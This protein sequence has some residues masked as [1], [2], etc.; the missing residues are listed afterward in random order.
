MKKQ[1]PQLTE[2]QKHR[3]KRQKQSHKALK[4][5]MLRGNGLK[6]LFLT[7][8]LTVGIAIIVYTEAQLVDGFDSDEV[9]KLNDIGM[10]I[11]AD[12]GFEGRVLTVAPSLTVYGDDRRVK[13]MKNAEIIPDVQIN[14]KRKSEGVYELTPVV[15]DDKF[16]LNYHFS[17]STVEVQ[18]LKAEKEQYDVLERHYAIADEG[19]YIERM[20]AQ[21]MAEVLVTSEQAMEIG[22]VVADIDAEVIKKSGIYDADLVILDKR[23]QIL[24]LPLVKPTIKIE[25]TYSE[26]PWYQRQKDILALK[27]E[28]A[29]LET[30][31]A[32]RR[33]RLPKVSDLLQRSDLV[34]EISFR[35][36]RLPIKQK[37]LIE[38]ET[39][40]SEA[41]ANEEN[42]KKSQ[43]QQALKDGGLFVE[44]AEES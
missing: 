39:G 36:T 42:L 4:R 23:G 33:E 32:E 5:L 13:S 19:Y 30:E 21:E 22:Y 43:A 40:L 16:D 2:V 34:K 29:T 26:L 10:T 27:A 7:L 20:I 12:K 31:L 6:P 17:P 9:Y 44:D 15:K 3:Q 11:I 1:K 37:E 38:K 14:A 35:E 25:V 41:K 24:D 18:I 28:I 8:F